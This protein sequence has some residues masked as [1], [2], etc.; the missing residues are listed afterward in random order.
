MIIFAAC[1][2]EISSIS[3]LE[4]TFSNLFSQSDSDIA[5]GCTR[6]RLDRMDSFVSVLIAGN[7][8]E[9]WALPSIT[10]TFDG[11]KGTLSAGLLAPFFSAV[12]GSP[13][14]A[15]LSDETSSRYKVLSRSMLTNMSFSNDS[16]SKSADL[17]SIPSSFGSNWSSVNAS[18]PPSAIG[19]SAL[20]SIS[21][22]EKSAIS[23]ITVEKTPSRISPPTPREQIFPKLNV[24]RILR[25]F[26][27]PF[28]S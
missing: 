23:P 13:G 14:I 17:S 16:N 1:E 27:S 9:F 5:I 20:L 26:R 21:Q 11:L 15:P 18:K 10:T 22:L 24:D 25:S 7:F 3:S 6:L 8:A 28:L 19:A 12:S 4:L 2:N